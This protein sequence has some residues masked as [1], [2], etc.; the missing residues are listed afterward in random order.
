MIETILRDYLADNV[1]VPVLMERPLSPPASYI[2]LDRTGGSEEDKI[3]FARFAVQSYAESL[4]EAAALSHSVCALLDT[5]PDTQ[6][7]FS[8]IKNS[9]YNFTDTQTKEYRYQAVY[10]IYY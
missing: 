5:M 3:P 2:I 1:S 4:Y 7:V 6:P 10:T 9:E 8:A